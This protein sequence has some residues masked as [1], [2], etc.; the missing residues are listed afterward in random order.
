M[1]L[2]EISLEIAMANQVLFGILMKDPHHMC[3]QAGY[4]IRSG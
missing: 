4:I 2:E 3:A 1:S